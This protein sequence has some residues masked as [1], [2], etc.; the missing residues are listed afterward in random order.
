MVV[1]EN[2][3]VIGLGNACWDTEKYIWSSRECE[4]LCSRASPITPLS[5]KDGGLMK[6]SYWGRLPLEKIVQVPVCLK[7][8]YPIDT[9]A[10]AAGSGLLS[11][12]IWTW[13]YYAMSCLTSTS[14]SASVSSVW[15]CP[16]RSSPW[17][18]LT[19][20]LRTESSVPHHLWRQR[21]SENWD[22][23]ISTGLIWMNSK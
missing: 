15:H 6:M 2:W 4:T 3:I 11:S 14:F 8:G 9:N 22:V 23:W 1:A 10:I 13:K 5:V 7:G 17:G 20:T 18:S 12:Y 16:G 19:L 21:P